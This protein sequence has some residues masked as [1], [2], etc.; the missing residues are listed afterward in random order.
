M[1]ELLERRLDRFEALL[2]MTERLDKL[3]ELLHVAEFKR[4]WAFGSATISG[5]LF[6]SGTSK[7]GVLGHISNAGVELFNP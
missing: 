1:I 6:A 7:L 4:F 5:E 2:N 3:S